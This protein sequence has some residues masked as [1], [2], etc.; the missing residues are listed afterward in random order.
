MPEFSSFVEYALHE[1]SYNAVLERHYSRNQTVYTAS[2]GGIQEL[3]N[4][5]TI[6]SWGQNQA[7]SITE[8][9]K[10][11]SVEFEI[12]FTTN[13]HQYRAY[14]FKWQTDLF[15]L[16][17][18][19]IDFGFVNIGDSSSQSIE[20]YNRKDKD[21]TINEILVSSSDFIV[22]DTLPLII[23]SQKKLA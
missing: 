8:V 23:P 5:N 20:L 1:E 21:V 22:K 6:I 13:A 7:P 12:E 4:G 15:S 9:N 2:R 16:S 3:D 10:F 19:T 11:D 14:R 17:S 18:D